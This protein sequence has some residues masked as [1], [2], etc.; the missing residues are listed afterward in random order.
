MPETI[1][2]SNPYL[3]V[4]PEVR[5]IGVWGGLEQAQSTQTHPIH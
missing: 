1:F 5:S 3:K 4:A 2:V